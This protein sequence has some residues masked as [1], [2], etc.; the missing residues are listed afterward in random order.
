MEGDGKRNRRKTE[1]H[2]ARVS[3]RVREKRKNKWER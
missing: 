1:K 3:E 2:R